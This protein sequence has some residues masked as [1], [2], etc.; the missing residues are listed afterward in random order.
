M[1]GLCMAAQKRLHLVFRLGSL[2]EDDV[3]PLRLEVAA[4]RQGLI[5][6]RGPRARR[7][8]P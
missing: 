6:N 8:A 3:R 1:H 5:R 2:E 7:S 4:A